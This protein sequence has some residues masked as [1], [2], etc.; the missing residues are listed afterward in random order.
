[1]MSAATALIQYLVGERKLGRRKAAGLPALAP[2]Q[3]TT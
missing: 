1:L 2:T 3:G